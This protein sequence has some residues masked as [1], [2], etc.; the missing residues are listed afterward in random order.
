MEGIVLFFAK[1]LFCFSLFSPTL[2]LQPRRPN[3]QRRTR[4]PPPRQQPPHFKHGVRPR[5][6]RRPGHSGPGGQPGAAQAGRRH[7]APG[8]CLGGGPEND[9][10]ART[11]ARRR[12]P[13]GRRRGVRARRLC[14]TGRSERQEAVCQPAP[15][16]ECDMAG[17][18]GGGGGAGRGERGKSDGNTPPMRGR[19]L[20]LPDPLPPRATPQHT[21]TQS[22]TLNFRQNPTFEDCFPGSEKVYQEV[23]HEG[24]VLRVS[25]KKKG[26]G[27]GSIA[28]RRSSQFGLFVGGARGERAGGRT[29]F[30]LRP[31][32][33][34]SCGPRPGV[35]GL[36]SRACARQG[37]ACNGG[38]APPCPLR[39]D[40]EAK[41]GGRRGRALSWPRS[42]G[43]ASAR[44][45]RRRD[46]KASQ[47]ITWE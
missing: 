10:D 42:R 7:D 15:G 14:R 21:H 35:C 40:P 3:A 17:R 12:A 34:Q 43:H 41:S 47:V 29:A 4:P 25:V 22:S 20:F 2:I 9:V 31:L 18:G 46:G 44:S 36:T 1:R 27:G 11:P 19:L 23:D 13:P 38:D 45:R 37:G 30:K 8:A 26:R 33:E 5:P 28:K 6:R 16:R 24:T 39:P 32:Q